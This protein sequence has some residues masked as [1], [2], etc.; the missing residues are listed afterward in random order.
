MTA[1][2]SSTEPIYR[3]LV[4][5]QGDAAAAAQEAAQKVE[6]TAA[7]ALDWSALRA[8]TTRAVAH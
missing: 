4:E 5:E 7:S 8:R 2:I 1:P 6:H 3:E